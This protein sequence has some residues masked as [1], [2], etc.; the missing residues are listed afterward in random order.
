MSQG[1]SHTDGPVSRRAHLWLLVGLT[2]WA[3]ALMSWRLDAKSLWWDESLS[4]YRAQ[5]SLAGILSGRIDFAG[6]ETVDQHPP[7]Y[8]ALLKIAVALGGENDLALRLPSVAFGTLLTP[9][10]YALGRRLRNAQTGL[11]AAA[12]GANSPFF[13]WYAQEARM[14]TQVT[15]LSLLATYALWVALCERRW[16]WGAV[17]ALALAAAITTHYLALLLLP[18]YLGLAL[19]LWPARRLSATS[20]IARRQAAARWIGALAVLAFGMALVIVLGRLPG[21]VPPPGAYEVFVPLDRMLLDALN[22]FSLGLSVTLAEHW[23]LLIPF[24]VIFLIGLGSLGLRRDERAD[25][26]IAIAQGPSRR[27]RAW[28]RAYLLV[29]YWGMPVAAIWLLSHWVPFYVNSR[30]LMASSPAFYL[31]LALGLDALWA[32]RRAGGLLALLVLLALM[33]FSTSR[34]LCDPYYRSKEDYR[35]AARLI[36]ERECV[37]DAILITGPE[38]LLAFTHYY[39]G[40]AP[41][42][43]LPEGNTPWSETERQL[44]ALLSGH[45]R[46]WHLQAR[47]A[48]TDPNKHTERWLEGQATAVDRIVLPS[49]GFHMLLTCYLTERPDF[50]PAP[51]ETL[52]S[53]EGLRLSSV[54]LRH[55]G[56]DSQPHAK[57]INSQV[58]PQVSADEHLVGP[59]P[60]G[61][62]LAVDLVW[63]V[64]H[65]LPDLKMSLRLV[66]GQ[67]VWAQADQRPWELLPTYVW[68]VGKGM[69][70]TLVL[71]IPADTPPNDYWVQMWVY[72]TEGGAPLSFVDAV[73]GVETPYIML[74]RVAIAAPEAKAGIGQA[75]PPP[76][77]AR[78]LGGASFGQRLD[79]LGWLWGNNHDLRAGESA[80]L[81]LFWRVRQPLDDDLALVI[82]WVDENGKVWR[83]E[84]KPLAGNASLPSRW[85][86]GGQVHGVVTLSAP[87]DGTPG[88][89]EI[90]ILVRDGAGSYLWLRRGPWPWAGRDLSIGQITLSP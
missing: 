29:G 65:S 4:L 79:L 27:R 56:M 19:A 58:W 77:V 72:D 66:Q 5:Q 76:G 38:S 80:T 8:F 60:A 67:A 23:P 10:L 42:F 75:V 59:V 83:S 85:P 86:V 71:P 78:P 82:N 52:A 33:G 34:Y 43:A 1:T 36:Q 57:E 73:S 21:L 53:L 31:T 15:A 6:I 45:R 90:H 70:H 81:H 24:G 64:E 41:V 28:A 30:Y 69:V 51:A 47:H 44:Q 17:C 20:Q 26:D 50:Q 88:A 11:F 48:F 13:L 87:A 49:A 46:I 2:L 68:P 40:D 35:G 55:R 16:N 7:F 18:F 14:Y 12:L 39:R 37:D 63:A 74:A 25:V 89:H 9:L 61:Q 84:T 62:P 22:S 3:F 54:A 32:R